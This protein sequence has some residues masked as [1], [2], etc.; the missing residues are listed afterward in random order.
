MLIIT[1]AIVNRTAGFGLGL[2]EVPRNVRS[3]VGGLVGML[4]EKL[5]HHRRRQMNFFNILCPC[6]GQF[7]ELP[8]FVSP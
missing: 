2:H 5:Y 6:G 3:L 4:I 1:E 8:Q 7:I